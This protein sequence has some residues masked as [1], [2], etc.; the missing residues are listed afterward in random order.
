MVVVEDMCHAFAT[1][2]SVRHGGDIV[3]CGGGYC[4][5]DATPK[6]MAVRKKN[7]MKPVMAKRRSERKKANDNT[8][9]GM[10]RNMATDEVAR[11]KDQMLKMAPMMKTKITGILA[12]MMQRKKARANGPGFG[13]TTSVTESLSLSEL[14]LS[15][16]FIA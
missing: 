16:E 5:E 2:F 12:N 1:T 7:T 6:L 14:A 4:A 10:I 13:K 8:N 3:W 9:S 11:S 15:L